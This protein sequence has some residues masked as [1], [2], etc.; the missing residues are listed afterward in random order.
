MTKILSVRLK[1]SPHIVTSYDCSSEESLLQAGL[2]SGVP[3]RYK[4]TNGSCGECRSRLIHGEIRAI[5]GQDY[6]LAYREKSGGWF[7]S[8]THAPVTA[9]EMEA[10]LFSSVVEIPHQTIQT[11]VKSVQFLQQEL[12]ILTLRTPRSNTFQFLAGQ[13]ALLS[14]GQAVQRYPVASCPC[15]GL[16]LEFHVRHNERDPFSKLLFSSLRR[17]DEVTVDGPRGTFLL[18]E[19][20]S[21][22][23]VFIAWESGFASIQSLMEHLIS[24]EMENPLSFYWVSESRPYREKR[25]L[26]WSGVIDSYHYQWIHSD[27]AEYGDPVER[28]LEQ[29]Q[30]HTVVHEADLYITAPAEILISL[31]ERLLNLGLPEEQL[32]ASPL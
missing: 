22:P 11:R 14:C 29:L 16:E 19:G 26:S 17:G 1:R 10:P 25:A 2:R 24:L 6:P 32:R 27:P 13:D 31:G 9:V 30:Q 3:L 4:C 20:S 8:C 7:L 23:I 12:A 28:L 15:S 18:N 5:R 21:R